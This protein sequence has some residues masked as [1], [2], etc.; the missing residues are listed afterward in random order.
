MEPIIRLHR[1]RG[2]NP[3]VSWMDHLC[4][5][6]TLYTL[7]P[8]KENLAR[9][10]GINEG[11][12]SSAIDRI[13][14]ILWRV[15]K[16]RWAPSERRPT[17]LMQTEIANDGE[18]Q[19]TLSPY[20]HIALL[21][22]ST[23]FQV[24]RPKGRFEEAKHYWDE[25]NGIY[26]LKKEVAVLAAPPH[27]AMFVSQG[28]VGSDHDFKT[29]KKI[30]NK[31]AAYLTKSPAEIS[32]LRS[33]DGFNGKWSILLDKGYIGSSDLTPTIRRITLQKVTPRTTSEERMRN[34]ELA[35]LRVPVESFFGRMFK[36]FAFV[37]QPYPYDH[38]NFD[39]DMDIIIM[40]TNE[41]IRAGHPLAGDERDW[42]LAQLQQRKEEEERKIMKVKEAKK[43][44][45]QRKK[46][47]YSEFREIEEAHTDDEYY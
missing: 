28:T 18:F 5:I 43:M 3:S 40:L 21:G 25:K 42:Y 39:M 10:A 46:R 16:A 31:Y 7:A 24:N 34:R 20:A 6:L 22:D 14:P 2:P 32:A 4:L 8:K 45:E 37:R 15:L 12:C 47:R 27:F 33:V 29:H 19:E 35:A 44:Y 41:N 17:P 13:R 26:A 36:L 30:H 23:S 11:A 1:K 9:F 38:S